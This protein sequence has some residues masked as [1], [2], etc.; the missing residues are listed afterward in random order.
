MDELSKN[1]YEGM[2]YGSCSYLERIWKLDN[3]KTW[4]AHYTDKTDYTKDYYIWQLSS[5]GKVDGINGAVDLDIL[6]KK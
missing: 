6:Y 3:Y 5:T 1:N 2:I 4:L